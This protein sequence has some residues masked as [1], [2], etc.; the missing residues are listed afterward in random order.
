[1]KVHCSPELQFGHVNLDIMGYW[2]QFAQV[3]DN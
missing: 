3:S 2:Y 1:M